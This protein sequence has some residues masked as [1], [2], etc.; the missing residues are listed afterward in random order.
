MSY[1]GDKRS[2]MSPVPAPKTDELVALVNK[3]NKEGKYPSELELVRLRR[4]IDQVESVD[5]QAGFSFRGLYHAF[6]GE[7]EN[8]RKWSALALRNAPAVSDVYNNYACALAR[9][10][11]WDGAV[12]MVLDGIKKCGK[13]M[14]LAKTLIAVAYHSGDH[15]LIRS[16]LPEYERLA[17]KPH[18]VAN[19]IQEDAEDE[20]DLPEIIKEAERDGYIPWEQVKEELGL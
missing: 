14:N 11:D 7:E 10:E 17:G 4:L 6:K 18:E 5:E 13:D 12:R 20:A 15:E 3:L 9:L 16:W 8:A 19:W 2:S 1:M